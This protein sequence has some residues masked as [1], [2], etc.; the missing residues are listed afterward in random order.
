MDH[1]HSHSHQQP[2]GTGNYPNP[3][4]EGSGTGIYSYNSS[5]VTGLPSTENTGSFFRYVPNKK[6]SSGQVNVDINDKDIH[7]QGNWIKALGDV[8][9]Q[10]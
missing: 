6:T 10:Y 4:I 3:S 8:I 2:H 9:A 7:E 5:S 1:G